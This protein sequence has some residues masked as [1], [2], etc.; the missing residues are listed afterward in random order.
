M[1][2]AVDYRQALL[3]EVEDL[4]EDVLANL[5]GIVRLFKTSVCEQAKRAAIELREETAQWDALS[6][7]ALTEFEKVLDT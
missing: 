6:D 2:T 7:E 5:V 4:P 3:D 1:E